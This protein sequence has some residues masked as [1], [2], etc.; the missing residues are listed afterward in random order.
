VGDSWIIRFYDGVVA[1]DRGRSLREI[2]RWPDEKLESTHDYIQWLFPLPERSGFNPEAPL[3][4]KET[5]RE[6]RSRPELR[7]RMRTSF[8][9]MLAFYGFDLVEDDTLR[10]IAS[11]AFEERTANW[12]TRSNHNHLRITRILKSLRLA[13]LEEEAEAF[14]RCLTEVYGKEAA[15]REPRISEET[16][17]FWRGAVA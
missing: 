14:F 13:G 9:R 4:D 6:F 16:F 2:W 7:A 3:F 5:Q 8:V 15:S 10:V 11:P 12:L 17:H 1:D